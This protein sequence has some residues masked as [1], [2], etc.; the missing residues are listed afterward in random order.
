MD[1]CRSHFGAQVL[2]DARRLGFWVAFIP[3]G[4]TWLLQ[5]LDFYVFA[6]YKA[7]LKSKFR[8]CLIQYGSVA[9][10]QWF[11]IVFQALTNF[12]TGQNWSPAFDLLGLRGSR[13]GLCATLLAHC[14]HLK[15]PVPADILTIDEIAKIFPR[16]CRVSHWLLFASPWG[17]R[18]RLVLH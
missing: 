7:F 8:D 13:E 14:P 17:V 10:P 4:L 18:R 6:K 11:A 12:M 3:A 15:T 9:V 16:G 1:V 5:P 2:E